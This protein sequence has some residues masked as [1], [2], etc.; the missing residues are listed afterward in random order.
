VVRPP[1]DW[2][3]SAQSQKWHSRR[4]WDPLGYLRARSLS[5]P[6]WPRDLPWLVQVLD[7]QRSTATGDLELYDVAVK[8]ARAYRSAKTNDEEAWDAF[9]EALDAYLLTVHREHLEGV[10]RAGRS[11]SV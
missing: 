8:K 2:L 6:D 10:R 4:L 7:R 5:N 9:L 3:P 1:P 11:G